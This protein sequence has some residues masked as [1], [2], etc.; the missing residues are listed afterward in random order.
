MPDIAVVIA[1]LALLAAPA[2][3]GDPP[4]PVQV[5]DHVV[6]RDGVP[7]RGIGANYFTLLSRVLRD[8]ADTSSLA[9]LDELG[10]AGVPFVRFMAGG[11]WPVEQKLYTDDPD[12][13]FRRFDLVVRAAERAHV[14]LIPSLF[15]HIATV[16][17]LVGEHLDRYGD[18]ASATIA[19]V[20]AY[21]ADVVRRYRGSPAI[22]AWE[23]GN[24]GNLWCDLPE[25]WRYRPDVWPQLGTPA[26]RD[27]HDELTWD[28]L[29]TAYLAFAATA[30][31]LDPARPVVTGN[32]M[33]RVSAWH[34]ANGRT[35][36][37]DDAAQFAA[38]LQRNDPDPFALIT[39]HIYPDK[40]GAYAGGAKTVGDAIRAAA[41]GAAA[42]GK[43][44]FLGE[45]GVEKAAGEAGKAT[46]REILDAIVEQRVPLSA[47]WVFDHHGM[48]ADWNVE[49][50]GDR[51]WQLELVAEANGRL[52]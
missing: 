41:R 24:E 28:E 50:T 46:F 32:A 33:P 49:P 52:R 27:E 2:M 25:H 21:T 37:P 30:L 29:R 42:A 13:F 47:F 43:P 4:P 51:A 7:F 23:F 34:N 17:D 19:R 20:R 22:W 15:W 14:G 6:L 45:F 9:G 12:E 8:P 40:D 18:P 48:D 16:P 36:D 3:A 39:V 31:E 35:W 11:F 1:L 10:R 5:R 38:M 26:T 44:L